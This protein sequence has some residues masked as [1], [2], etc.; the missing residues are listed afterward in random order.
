MAREVK[1]GTEIPNVAD[2]ARTSLDKGDELDALAKLA[3]DRRDAL[4]DRAKAGEKVS[5]KTEL[6]KQHRE[7]REEV[8]GRQGACASR[9][10]IRR[11]C[12]GL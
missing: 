7:S 4:I 6:K 3:P 1:R 11:R 10:E 12:R 5:A 8:L 9:E 2:L